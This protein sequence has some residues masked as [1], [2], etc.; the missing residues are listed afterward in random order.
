MASGQ[1]LL[2]SEH[3][4]KGHWS[5]TASVRLWGPWVWVLSISSCLGVRAL[6]HQEWGGRTEGALCPAR[7]YLETKGATVPLGVWGGTWGN[8]LVRL[9]VTPGCP[10]QG[11]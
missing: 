10:A 1:A 5:G 4:L 8:W 3:G 9:F 11:Q 6:G 7:L 2:G